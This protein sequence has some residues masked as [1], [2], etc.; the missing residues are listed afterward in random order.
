MFGISWGGFNSL[1]MAMRNPPALKAIIAI[2]ATEEL[3][4]D[5][6]HF[7]D[8]MMHVDEYEQNVDLTMAMTRAPDFPTD[9]ASLAARF[10]R[11][12]WI[13]NYKRHPR[14]GAFLG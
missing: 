10:D 8:G 12:P 2:D 4:H 6:V 14:A 9:E 7:I 1:Q 13:I 11:T 3:F 5:D